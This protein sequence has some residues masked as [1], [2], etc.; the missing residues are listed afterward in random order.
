MAKF[1][2]SI[3]VFISLLLLSC[4]DDD[5]NPSYTYGEATALVNG[6]AWKGEAAL[7]NNNF[8]IGYNTTCYLTNN[9]GLSIE[10]FS[11]TRISQSPGTYTI[12]DTTGQLQQPIIGC[13]YRHTNE[14]GDVITGSFGPSFERDKN[15]ITVIS[16]DSIKQ[17]MTAEFEGIFIRGHK[18]PD[19]IVTSIDSVVVTNGVFTARIAD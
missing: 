8:G 4:K 12:F 14:A 3:A 17:E 19:H 13:R 10:E 9:V 1:H 5:Y 15:F 2:F 7:F 16:F 6:V 11:F 18:D